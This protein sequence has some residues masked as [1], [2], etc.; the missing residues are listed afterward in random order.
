MIYV[1]SCCIFF[2]CG[3]ELK[4]NY[5]LELRL[6]FV[7]L[8]NVLFREKNVWEVLYIVYKVENS[9][10][11]VIFFFIKKIF[12]VNLVYVKEFFSI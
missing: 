2:I 7:F 8:G 3:D 12:I 4:I 6:M 10:L 9:N 11:E 1:K 5:V